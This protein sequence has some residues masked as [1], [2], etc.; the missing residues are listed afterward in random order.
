MITDDYCEQIKKKQKRK[1]MWKMTKIYCK[2]CNE[3]GHYYANCLAPITSAGLVVFRMK[4]DPVDGTKKIQLLM[5]RRKDTYGFI[6]IMRGK[7]NI[8]NRPYMQKMIDIMTMDEKK[9]ILK[10]DFTTLWTNLWGEKFFTTKFNEEEQ[11]ARNKLDTLREGILVSQNSVFKLSD[12]IRNSTTNYEEQEWG[13]PKGKRSFQENDLTCAMREFEEETEIPSQ[14]LRLVENCIPFEEIFMGTNFKTYKHLYYLAMLS[15][16]YDE[17]GLIELE[18]GEIKQRNHTGILNPEVSKVAWK[19]ID[20]CNY[21]V[22]EYNEEKIALIAN[23]KNTLSQFT[24]FSH[25][26]N[27]A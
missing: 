3:Q 17:H 20:E 27:V 21:I 4:T 18:D 11:M 1:H 8:Y 7:Y 15:D 2:N 5:I 10:D 19:D 6:E 13:F 24:I 12:L 23:V 26:K 22:R 14:M 16:D 9:R 25:L